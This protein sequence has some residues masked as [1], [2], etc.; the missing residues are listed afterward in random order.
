[1]KALEPQRLRAVLYYFLS[2][3]FMVASFVERHARMGVWLPCALSASL[4]M[5]LGLR[6]RINLT[7]EPYR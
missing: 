2:V 3:M 7:S 4:F 5:L 1:M 6:A